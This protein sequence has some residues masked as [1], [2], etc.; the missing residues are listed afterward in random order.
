MQHLRGLGEF[1]HTRLPAARL[2]V[3]ATMM[4]LSRSTHQGH[5]NWAL[6]VAIDGHYVDGHIYIRAREGSVCGR[7]GTYQ[8]GEDLPGKGCLLYV[9]KKT[10]NRWG[11]AHLFC[12]SAHALW[13]LAHPFVRC[14]SRRG[15]VDLPECLPIAPCSE[16]S[17]NPKPPRRNNQLLYA[18]IK[19]VRPEFTPQITPQRAPFGPPA[20][21]GVCVHTR[22]RL[23]HFERH[24]GLGLTGL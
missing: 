17:T 15:H 10:D 16:S 11:C 22:Q 12:F 2:P 23:G 1:G 7:G 20:A 4:P 14:S 5:V 24:M 3:A 13:L 19:P 9:M 21:L 6:V 8:N 18:P